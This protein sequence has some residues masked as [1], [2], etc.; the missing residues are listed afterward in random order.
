MKKQDQSLQPGAHKRIDVI[1]PAR[2]HLGFVDLHGGL[3]RNFGSLGLCLEDIATHVTATR[4]ADVIIQGPSG[5][6]A[7][8]FAGQILEYL[9]LKQG[10]EITVH[11]AIPE[12]AG[13]GSGTQLSLAVGTAI[14]KLYGSVVSTRKIAE[15]MDRGARSGIGVG[16]FSK[17]GFLVDG[18]RGEKTNIPPI[19][20]HLPFPEAW[21]IVL[22]FDHGMEGVNGLSEIE[23]FYRLPPIDEH[24][25]EYSCRL[26]LMQVLPALAEGDCDMF[27]AA[28]TEIQQI[29]GDH[30]ASAQGG[31]YFSKYVAQVL[32]Q[33]IEQ[34]ATGIGQSSWGPTGF[35]IFS[36]ETQ[37]YKALKEAREEWSDESRLTFKLCKARNEKAEIRVDDQILLDTTNLKSIS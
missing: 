14:S 27:G 33:F 30:F 28:I 32:P 11:Q 23:A 10:V 36:N 37:A 15:I 29:I 24:T 19:I 4:S 20:S 26:T 22:V 21:R 35:A 2:L 12:H 9:D 6:R 18:G 7:S 13:L 3:G 31:R 34:G 1:A 16:T 17:G 5:S 25:T 8:V